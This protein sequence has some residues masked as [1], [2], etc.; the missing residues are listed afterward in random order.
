MGS[1]AHNAAIPDNHPSADSVSV[2]DMAMTIRH[3]RTRGQAMYLF[4]HGV[5][6]FRLTPCPYNFWQFN[7]QPRPKHY[8]CCGYSQTNLTSHA[9]P[10]PR[11]PRP[12]PADPS[13]PPRPIATRCAA[14]V[15]DSITAIGRSP[16]QLA[17]SKF[18]AINRSLRS[19]IKIT[20]VPLIGR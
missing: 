19:P 11:Q 12:K 5:D 20:S 6:C 2:R 15:P 10:R 1:A 7:A 8:R 17:A 13:H 18:S 3:R 14:V 4:E 16:D 9:N